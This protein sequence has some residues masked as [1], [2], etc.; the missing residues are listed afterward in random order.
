MLHPSYTE[1]ME[2]INKEG[3]T[4]VI[5]SL[6]QLLREQERLLEEMNL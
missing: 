5:P 1:L 6:L 3:E 2:K 4:A